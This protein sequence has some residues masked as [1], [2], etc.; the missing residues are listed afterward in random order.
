MEYRYL[1][2]AK[3]SERVNGYLVYVLSREMYLRQ[4]QEQSGK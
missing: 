2:R 4:V 3:F 1:V